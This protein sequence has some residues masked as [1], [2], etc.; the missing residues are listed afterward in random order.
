MK[1]YIDNRLLY[2]LQQCKNELKLSKQDLG[3]C[4]TTIRRKA[5]DDQWV[6]KIKQD[7]NDPLEQYCA[8]WVAK[9]YA[10]KEAKRDLRFSANTNSHPWGFKTLNIHLSSNLC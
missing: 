4:S 3:A 10:Q 8:G 9:G 7:C 1:L 5:I 6:F 2:G